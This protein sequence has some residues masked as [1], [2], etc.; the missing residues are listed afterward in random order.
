MALRTHVV[1]L[2]RSACVLEPA[3][4]YSAEAHIRDGVCLFCSQ[5][6]HWCEF[7]FVDADS[8]C[9]PSPYQRGQQPS[10]A[11][12]MEG[13]L[14]L[15]AQMGAPGWLYRCLASTLKEAGPPVLG[16]EYI[17]ALEKVQKVLASFRVEAKQRGP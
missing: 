1:C 9:V 13:N 17:W 12:Y 11:A 15:I 6:K 4:P 7:F 2:H 5:R 3:R 14:Q 8:G 10:P 16:Q